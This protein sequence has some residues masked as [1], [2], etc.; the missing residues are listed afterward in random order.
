VALVGHA[1]G[2]WEKGGEGCNAE[3]GVREYTYTPCIGEIVV[4]V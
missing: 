4:H 1:I 2:E 3:D